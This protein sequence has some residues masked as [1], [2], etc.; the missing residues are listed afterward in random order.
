MAGGT[1]F[2]LGASAEEAETSSRASTEPSSTVSALTGF[3]P[4]RVPPGY[5]LLRDGTRCRCIRLWS[6][7][8]RF[9][10]CGRAS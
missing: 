9:Y 6:D 2:W 4:A 1:Y 7:G 10:C 8:T 3:D 5:Y